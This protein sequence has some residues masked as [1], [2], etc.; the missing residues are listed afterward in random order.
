MGKLY[1][2]QVLSTDN[3]KVCTY[4]YAYFA[5]STAFLRNLQQHQR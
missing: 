3:D 2:V 5:G 4:R 1:S